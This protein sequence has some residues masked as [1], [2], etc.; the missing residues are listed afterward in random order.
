MSRRVYV[1]VLH[2]VFDHRRSPDYAGPPVPCG[3]AAAARATKVTTTLM[4]TRTM[5]R[6]YWPFVWTPFSFDRQWALCGSHT[7]Q[8]NP[9]GGFLLERHHSKINIVPT[10]TFM[11]SAAVEKGADGYEPDFRRFLLDCQ[12]W[13]WGWQRSSG[14]RKCP[15]I[16]TE[17]TAVRSQPSQP[18][19]QSFDDTPVV[20]VDNGTGGMYR[21]PVHACICLLYTSD[22]AD[23]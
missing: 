8:H 17:S 5:M 9:L 12:T 16:A 20:V 13:W 1:C 6:C 18:P 7:H 4:T 3:I 23:E 11:V 21:V 14:P 15:E 2:D 19:P 10:L 22:A